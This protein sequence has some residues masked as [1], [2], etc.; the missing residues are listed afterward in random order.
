MYVI[1]DNLSLD[2][3]LSVDVTLQTN[4]D[5]RLGS[6]RCPAVQMSIPCDSGALHPLSDVYKLF[7]RKIKLTYYNLS[8][9]QV[10]NGYLCDI[11]R[12]L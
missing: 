1:V 9:F 2:V 5:S 10:L 3:G 11:I 12:A 6:I 8:K 4:V 7:H